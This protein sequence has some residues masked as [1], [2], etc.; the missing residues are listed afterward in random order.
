MA[1]L[2]YAQQQNQDARYLLL[3]R[4]DNMSSQHERHLYSA[5]NQA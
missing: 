4:Q 5:L 2:K 1:N 3:F